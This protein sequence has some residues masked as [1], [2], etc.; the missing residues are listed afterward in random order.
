MENDPLKVSAV[1]SDPTR[2][3]IYEHTVTAR[4]PVTVQEIAE[5]FSL[6]PNV[7]RMHLNKLQAI[8]LLVARPEKSGRGGRP[9]VVYAASGEAV[10]ITVPARD[11]ALLANLLSDALAQTGRAGLSAL[12]QVGHTYGRHLAREALAR[13]GSEPGSN[14]AVSVLEAC[15]SA[16][17]MHGLGVEIQQQDGDVRLGLVFNRCGF[18]EV[19]LRNPQ[20][21]CHL[22]HAMVQGVAETLVVPTDTRVEASASLPNGDERCIF[23]L[24]GVPVTLTGDL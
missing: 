6:H 15:V 24:P 21:I 7:A 1:L 22:C 3:A 9:A 5:Q 17:S 13:E 20:H 23:T 16:L 18:R 12:K 2:Y 4:Q 14:D 19:A 11:Y 10:S 8:G